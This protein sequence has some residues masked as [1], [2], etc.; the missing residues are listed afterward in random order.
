MAEL[1]RWESPPLA[2]ASASGVTGSCAGA[3]HNWTLATA[4][5]SLAGLEACFAT[6]SSLLCRRSYLC[7][8]STER[9]QSVVTSSRSTVTFA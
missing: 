9:Y 5:D 7:W 2:D 3:I 1:S 4:Q 6:N 8:A